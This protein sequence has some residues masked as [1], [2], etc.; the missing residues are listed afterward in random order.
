MAPKACGVEVYSDGP[1]NQ[2]G[3][4]DPGS[5]VPVMCIYAFWTPLHPA[6]PVQSCELRRRVRR[7]SWCAAAV[8]AA[9]DR[10]EPPAA[11]AA[12]GGPPA[13]EV[14]VSRR[15]CRCAHSAARVVVSL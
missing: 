13:S 7:D 14:G 1:Q 3:E 5:H 12:G 2:A 4:G 8:V 15:A 6:L 10:L 9:A 11:A